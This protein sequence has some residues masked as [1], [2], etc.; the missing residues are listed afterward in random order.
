MAVVI[1]KDESVGRDVSCRGCGSRVRYFKN[2]LRSYTK[3]D[4]AGGRDTYWEISCPGCGKDIPVS[5]WY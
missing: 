3:S 1:G 4:Y 5:E 2:D